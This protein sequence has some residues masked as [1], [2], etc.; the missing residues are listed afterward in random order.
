MGF[1]VRQV[2]GPATPDDLSNIYFAALELVDGDES[3]G[4]A[5]VVVPGYRD[6]DGNVQ[7]VDA[8]HRLPV[9]GT[10]SATTANAR[11][12]YDVLL[13]LPAGTTDVVASIVAAGGFKFRGFVGLGTGDAIWRVLYDGTPRYAVRTNIA[14]PTARLK[15][16]NPD[17]IADG[18]LVAVVATNVT[19]DVGDFEATILGE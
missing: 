9:D 12:A 11:N 4:I 8:A 15:L 18:V 7:V 1:V 2:D 13:G 16:P 17:P 10:F 5:E 3:Q 6:A 19:D 14:E